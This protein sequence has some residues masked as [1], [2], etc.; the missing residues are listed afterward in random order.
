MAI[1]PAQR[2][3][4]EGLAALKALQDT[5]AVV[6]RSADLTRAQREGLL[7]NGFLRQVVKGWYMPA[8]PDEVAGDT[9]PW[10]AAMRDF[11]AGYCDSRFGAQWYLSPE[12][13]L[14]L[15]AGSTRLPLQVVVHSPLAKNGLLQLP[16]GC[17]LLDY[18]AK[19]FAP[20]DRV[21]RVLGLQVL[22]LPQALV[23]V[24]EVF[25]RIRP[26]DAQIALHRLPDASDLNRELLEG[27]RSVVAGRL[28]G[29]L[30]AVGRPA[31]ADDVLA[32]MRAA[33][34]VVTETDPFDH[35]AGSVAEASTALAR[36][37][38]AS[39]YVMRM[40]LMWRAM[41]PVVLK[42]FAP[43]P[44]LPADAK[45]Y[46]QAVDDVYRTDAYHSLSIEGYRV[47]DALIQ[48]VTAGDWNPQTHA[49]D[50]DSRNAMAARGYWLAHNAVKLSIRK[51]LETGNARGA[52]SAHA[53]AAGEVA[54]ADHRTWFRQ[55]F[56]PS[57]DA[58][59]LVAADLA[60][61]RAHQVYIRNAAHV[62]PPK[63][64]V[65]DMMPALF[66]LLAGEPSAAV[67]AVLGHFMFVFIHPYMDGNGRIGRFLMNVMLASGGY[68]WTVIRL[69]RRAEYMAALDAAS[70]EANIQPFARFVASCMRHRVTGTN[71]TRR[72]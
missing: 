47:T 66:D 7:A 9:T 21:E 70:A 63:E 53:S 11:I 42:A 62:P 6:L 57:V 25:F 49:N 54:R 30:R 52:L 17:S 38:S 13:S 68:P 22:A 59:I 43:E 29:A 50:A 51:L 3:L 55:L 27:G 8:R 61:Y 36:S 18:Q 44:G 72:T 39:P 15:H 65:R 20:A 40:R 5:G 56:A 48:R 12:A 26:A 32:T 2:R 37:R 60:G 24:A 35:A 71:S 46:L 28:C 10:F 58:R 23:R 34:Y 16:G 67:R 41:R 4:A 64:A 69:E 31:L 33:G 19:D 14:S 1:A 45:A